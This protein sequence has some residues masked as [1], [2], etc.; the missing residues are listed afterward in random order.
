MVLLDAE[1]ADAYDRRT[2][3]SS[4]GYLFRMPIVCATTREF[5]E[6]VTQRAQHIVATSV[7]SS[8]SVDQISDDP[9]RTFFL[10]GAEKEGCWPILRACASAT[11]A[12]PI[13]PEAESLNVS[14]AAGIFLFVR[15][16]RIV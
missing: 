7:R 12:I 13:K 14:V 1:Q 16:R 6:F 2:I 8:E 3:R 11:V 10:M 9:R 15:S 4:R 5:V